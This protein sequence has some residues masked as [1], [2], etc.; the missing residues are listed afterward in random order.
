MTTWMTYEV[1]MASERPMGDAPQ[2][3]SYD[4]DGPGSFNGL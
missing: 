3:T 2:F 4:Y 1:S